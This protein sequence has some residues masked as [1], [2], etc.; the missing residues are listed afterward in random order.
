MEVQC[1]RNLLVVKRISNIQIKF[2]ELSSAVVQLVRDIVLCA[3]VCKFKPLV[4]SE[5][6]TNDSH[7]G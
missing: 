1:H 7:K 5:I 3:W 6:Q 4:N 2:G